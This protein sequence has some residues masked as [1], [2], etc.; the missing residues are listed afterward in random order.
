MQLRC[1]RIPMSFICTTTHSTR[2]LAT[3]AAAFEF[4]DSDRLQAATLAT[5]IVK[6][7]TVFV[8]NFERR[9][10]GPDRV[11]RSGNLKPRDD[12][13]RAIVIEGVRRKRHREMV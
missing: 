13:H 10:R 8:R 7:V 3:F 9:E 1:G 5:L 2:G 4:R 11:R 6:P 12:Q